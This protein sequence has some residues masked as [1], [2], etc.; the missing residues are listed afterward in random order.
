MADPGATFFPTQAW[1][2]TCSQGSGLGRGKGPEGL[3]TVC[4]S[5]LPCFAFGLG[6]P[7]SP[8]PA[9]KMQQQE[10]MV[11]STDQRRELEKFFKRNRYA[12][13]EERETPAARRN[14]QKHQV[15]VQPH[16][17]TRPQKS[18][19]RLPLPQLPTGHLL[20]LL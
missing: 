2:F 11:Y 15:Q 10:R 4:G 3:G 8:N 17:Q 5:I 18:P 12:S 14:L 19:H 13:Y 9:R 20:V 7:L 6:S 1:A 16:P